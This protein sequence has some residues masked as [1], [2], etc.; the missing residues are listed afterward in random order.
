VHIYMY[1]CTQIF[2]IRSHVAKRSVVIF[3]IVDNLFTN[4]IQSKHL[5]DKEMGKNVI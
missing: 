5:R 2:I 3:N 1:K 4:E